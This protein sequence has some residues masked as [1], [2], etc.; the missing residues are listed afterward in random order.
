MDKDYAAAGDLQRSTRRGRSMERSG[1]HQPPTSPTTLMMLKISDLENKHNSLSDAY[2]CNDA[3]FVSYIESTNA[4]FNDLMLKLEHQQVDTASVKIRDADR[5]D[6]ITAV[7][8]ALT[9]SVRALEK[10]VRGIEERH[11]EL[12][13]H[14]EAPGR[15]ETTTADLALGAPKYTEPPAIPSQPQTGNSCP[16]P[17]VAEAAVPLRGGHGAKQEPLVTRQLT[18]KTPD[19]VG[20]VPQRSAHQNQLFKDSIGLTR[21]MQHLNPGFSDAS[22]DTSNMFISNRVP[23]IN[24]RTTDSLTHPLAVMLRSL[25]ALVSNIIHRWKQ[26]S[27]PGTRPRSRCCHKRMSIRSAGPT[28]PRFRN[29]LPN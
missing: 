6:A 16:Q 10:Q 5:D 24:M 26:P 23:G 25:A 1:R 21:F 20:V 27:I 29:R 2:N 12:I 9:Q 8:Q 17:V 4:T 14:V 18:F 22:L 19:A 28:T 11:V 15:T 13:I 7:E 3:R